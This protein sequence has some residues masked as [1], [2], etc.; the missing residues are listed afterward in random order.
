MFDMMKR[1]GVVAGSS[2]TVLATVLGVAGLLGGSAAVQAAPVAASQVLPRQIGYGGQL[3]PSV[4]GTFPVVVRLYNG[5]DTVVHEETVSVDIQQGKFVAMV[6]GQV[7]L[8]AV[9]RDART[10][11][12]FFQGNLVDTVAVTRAT[13]EDA[14]ANPAAF[15]GR[16]TLVVPPELRA[17]VAVP[18]ALGGTCTLNA[19]FVNLTAGS[20]G[21]NVPACSSGVMVSSGI[22]PFTTSFS[23]QAL[24]PA[25]A[26]NDWSLNFTLG[27]SATVELFGICCP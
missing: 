3:A 27:T 21:V 18:R 23:L 5:N 1:S 8:A 6:G 13:A 15:A 7:D 10:M 2:A 20:W 25:G 14:R 12:V 4:T 9:L 22:L 26:L 17:P 11:R 24:I 19:A 16:R